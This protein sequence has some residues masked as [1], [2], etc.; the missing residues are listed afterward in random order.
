MD[1]AKKLNLVPKNDFSDTEEKVISELFSRIPNLP[2]WQLE[3][4][5]ALTLFATGWLRRERNFARARRYL[6][7]ARACES[8]LTVRVSPEDYL[9]EP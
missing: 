2:D 7:L 1:T 9:E 3:Q 8:L 5:K 4:L 6:R